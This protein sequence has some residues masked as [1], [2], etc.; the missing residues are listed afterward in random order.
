MVT[1]S[2]KYNNWGEETMKGLKNV[3]KSLT[4]L[5]TLSMLFMLGSVPVRATQETIAP[6]ANTEANTDS[7][8]ATQAPAEATQA[9]TETPAPQVDLNGTYHASLGIQTCN[10]LWINRPAYYNTELD[11]HFGTDKF[12]VMWSGTESAGNYAEYAGTFNDVVI[13][14]NGT[15]TVSLTNADFAGETSVSQLHVATDIPMNDTIKFTDVSVKFNNKTIAKFDEAYIETDQKYN[16][17][18]IDFVCINHWRPQLVEMLAAQGQSENGN[19][20]DL[21]IGSG[22]DNIEVTFTISG[23]AYDKA[24]EEAPE[25]TAPTAAA[26]KAT[27][28]SK[29]NPMIP[30][31]ADATSSNNTVIIVI[32]IA[33][34][35]VA[36]IV[37]AV[38]ISKK[39]KAK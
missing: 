22:N 10:T 33:V 35:V 5:L 15:Y 4:V 17:G 16:G 28:D 24:V 2:H 3:K 37:A 11:A 30:T 6:E 34:V 19:G 32:V 13:E 7:V 8:E 18:G 31:D 29:T 20:I 26:V 12:T 36:A 9:P 1:H 23:F 14:G 21:L 38:V 39:K 25:E 27:D